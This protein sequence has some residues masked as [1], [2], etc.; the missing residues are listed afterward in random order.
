MALKDLIDVAGLPT[1]ASSR[2]REH[3][4]A[5][6]DSTVAA[7]LAE[8]GAVA[9]G[10]ATFALGTD[11]GG[12]IRVPAALN[13]VVGLKPTYGLVPVDGVV[14]L[15]WSL[16]HVGPLT[17]ATTT[18]SGSHPRS[19]KRY[20]RRQ[21]VSRIS[22]RGSWTWRSPWPTTSRARSGG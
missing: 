14:P 9:A 7:R 6:R 11:T 4:V 18:S 1:T 5:E 16:D 21:P 17:R 2:V 19:R 10:T 3:H 12:S 22:G 20:G 15:S 8:A 13:G